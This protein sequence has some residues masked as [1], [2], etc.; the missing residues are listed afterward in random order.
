MCPQEE[1]VAMVQIDGHK[2]HTYIKFID[3]NKVQKTLTST[4]EHGEFLHKNGVISKVWIEAADLET[5][6]VGIANI[7]PEVHDRAVRMG[8]GRYWKVKEVQ[9]EKL[10]RAYRYP[11]TNGIRIA[12]ASLSH[13]I[14]SSVVIAG[15]RTLI[16]YEG[17]LT[18][19]Y[20]CNETGHLYQD[21]PQRRKKRKEANANTK[22]SWADVVARGPGMARVDASG[23]GSRVVGDGGG[24]TV[25]LLGGEYS[26]TRRGRKTP[27]QR[28]KQTDGTG[29]SGNRE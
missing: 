22:A 11:M 2:R 8:L 29:H 26:G 20:G 1:E 13:H 16:S 25:A 14:S 10:S 18:S 9:E 27:I 21:Y 15:Y 7:P 4:K 5:R 12:V 23:H 19:S 17:Q 24:E 6:R 3:Y 28:R